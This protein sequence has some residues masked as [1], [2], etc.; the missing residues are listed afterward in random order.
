M[1]TG[2]VIG[3]LFSHKLHWRRRGESQDKGIG[4]YPL[5]YANDS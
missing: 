4:L 5:S 3:A 2:D 1:W